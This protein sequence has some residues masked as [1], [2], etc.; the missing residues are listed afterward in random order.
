L[1]LFIAITAQARTK[2]GESCQ[3][4]GLHD[5]YILALSWQ[6]G[7]CEHVRSGLRKP[8]CVAM[9]KGQITI[10]H[11]TLHG[12]W[13]NNRACGKEYGH[14]PGPSLRLRQETTTYIQPWMPNFYYG[15][16][17]GEYQWRKHGTCQQG[18]DDDAY[19]RKAV[20]AVITINN[21]LAG[22][23]LRQSTGGRFSK[24]RFLEKIVQEVGDAGAADNVLLLCQGEYL[25]EIRM[26][27]DPQFEESSGLA[28]MMKGALPLRIAP[29]GRGC[30]QD[31][32]RVERSGH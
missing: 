30:R 2:S 16:D 23:Y 28:S 24:K 4:P 26:I 8:E 3:R 21:S 22:Q 10:D 31:R 13:P 25:Y 1:L 12:L 32:I 11:L 19:F 6:P 14:C 29:E 17:F 5:T 20:D 7:F 27:L 9:A 18:L 15:N